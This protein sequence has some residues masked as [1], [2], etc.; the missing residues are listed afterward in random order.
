MT[1]DKMVKNL[2]FFE[3][4]QID[5]YNLG[6]RSEFSYLLCQSDAVFINCNMGLKPK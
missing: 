6:I 3:N 1:F 5:Y 4:Y 2:P